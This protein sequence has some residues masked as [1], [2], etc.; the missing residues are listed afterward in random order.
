MIGPAVLL[1][2]VV[3]TIPDG[4]GPAD[5]SA[6][7]PLAPAEL[8]GRTYVRE[9]SLSPDG[10]RALIVEVDGERE[11]A[12]LVELRFDDDR[13]DVRGDDGAVERV[14]HPLPNDA[15]G[16]I[17]WDER[18]GAA[19]LLRA[20]SP[21]A[22]L[23]IVERFCAPRRLLPEAVGSGIFD[24]FWRTRGGASELL[25]LRNDANPAT[26][27]RE[28]VLSRVDLEKGELG[29]TL[30]RFGPLAIREAALSPDGTKLALVATAT[31]SF[32]SEGEPFDLW[33][34]DLGRSPGN[35]T[36]S[37]LE[38]G[39]AICL[40]DG[41]SI[42]AQ[43]RF[44]PDSSR[45]AFLLQRARV[46]IST[47]KRDVALLDVDG[48][49][50]GAILPTLRV[51][52]DDATVSIGDGIFGAGE[53]L[54]FLDERMLLL[55]TQHGL[56]DH[57]L[58]IELPERGGEG[59]AASRFVTFGE[60][61]WQRLSVAPRSRRLLALESGPALPE[62][63]V[64]ARW[65]SLAPRPVESPNERLGSRPLAAASTV[66]FRGADE[67][68]MEGLLLVPAGAPPFPTIF[69]LHG[70]SSGRQTLRFNDGYGQAYAALGYA[71]FAPNL[72]GSSGYSVAFNAA[73]EGDFGGRE[74]D[75]LDRAVDELVRRGVADP[76]RLYL[77]GHSY[78][79]FLVELELARSRR[80]AAGCAAAAVSDWES[81]AASSDLAALALVG[82][83]GPPDARRELY[84]ER[85]PLRRAERIGTPLLLVHGER[86]GR[87]P[88]AQ[89]ERL[90]AALLRGGCECELLR[91]PTIGHVP[92]GREAVL[93]WIGAVDGWFRR[94]E[95][96][97]AGS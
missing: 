78:G 50:R 71:V 83:G 70:G 8:F 84:A 27:K 9:L 32:A 26:G 64:A 21:R 69:L 91:L 57:V 56:A 18:T 80:F 53:A 85:S 38:T 1:S 14:A 87:V 48:G 13:R 93:R 94:H 30:A 11:T 25:V 96:R 90:H 76:Q 54:S 60:S 68:P 59:R 29:E 19:S 23:W 61:S 63:V 75:D 12:E 89:S 20:A 10:S 47:A 44:S 35:G 72:R 65:P 81:F 4:E 6:G 28:A 79:G 92:R 40:T 45:L 7:P 34:F 16:P 41:N 24:H 77:L 74:L 97:A 58:A 15:W 52:T 95:R 36:E 67:W 43:P 5:G 62:R 66:A 55:P 42:V 49:S 86:D 37:A 31:P 88:I 51:L 46:S 17:A 82:F 73:N 2:L 22:E 33:L 3:A 39:G